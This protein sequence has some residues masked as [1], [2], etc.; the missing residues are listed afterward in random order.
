M[1]F[2]SINFLILF[3][4]IF[5]LAYVIASPKLKNLV[6]LVASIVFFAFN[7]VYFLPL[8][9]VLILGNYN[10]AKAIDRTSDQEKKKHILLLTG[11]GIDLVLL[12]LFKVLATYGMGW[13]P[14]GLPATQ[15]SLVSQYLIPMG[16]SYIV[17][18]LISY[19]V[20]V[21]NG[22]CECEKSL[23]HFMLYVMMFPK[24]VVGPIVR[25]RDLA[26]PIKERQ[27]GSQDIAD[28]ARRFIQGLIKKTLIADTIAATINPAFALSTPNFPTWIA[29]FVLIG[30]AIQIYFDFSGFTDMAIGLGQMLGFR[31][32]EN[33]N[34]PYISKSVA[35]FWRRWHISLSTWFR[36]YVFYPL[37]FS[38][39]K[40]KFL[41]QPL[42]ILIV[43]LLVGLWHGLTLNFFIWG[44]V[45]GLAL[46]VE[47]T[48]LGKWLNKLWKPLQHIYTL[49]LILV[50]WVFFRSASPAYAIAFFARLVGLG[51]AI[52]PL[53]F[54][55]TRPLPIIDPSVWLALGLGIIFSLPV[56]PWFRKLWDRIMAKDAVGQVVGW[57]GPDLLLLAFLI[58]SFAAIVSRATV[59][60]SIYSK[61]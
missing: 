55:V 8:M 4:P 42:N 20:D 5:I 30:Y 43:F 58:L 47:A 17:F 44:G 22:I 24:I 40:F 50:G 25:Y 26:G 49:A 2:N 37:E 13:L 6:I 59:I 28:G 11:C 35:E 23:Y 46:A 12:L 15:V 39:R 19:L 61:F 33:F 41:V 9:L 34:Y 31:F 18:Q 60:T 52:T 38:R 7:Q 51:G 45:H 36:E 1:N 53:P 3:L 16:F 48:V 14:K 56:V 27:S 54:S 57:L 10:L 21:Y 29:W 32:M